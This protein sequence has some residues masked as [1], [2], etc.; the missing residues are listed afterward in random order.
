[1]K[2]GRW[3][4]L[5]EPL[6]RTGVRIRHGL[7]RRHLLRTRRLNHP[8]ISIGNLS[9][10][11][12]GK[13][14]LVLYFAEFLCEAGLAPAVLSRGYRGTSES[15]NR[16]VSDGSE[17]LAT[18]AEAGDEAC[19]LARNLR[20]VPV[21]MGKR[22]WVSGRLIERL[23]PHPDRVFL[24]DDGF[25]HLGLARDLDLVVC[26][27]TRPLLGDS[28]LP[29]G[30]LREPPRALARADAVLLTRCHLVESRLAR[31]D[32]EI[33]SLAPRAPCFQFRTE[34]VALREL[35]GGGAEE[36]SARAGRKGVVLAA[37]GNPDQFVKDVARAGVKIVN[38][39]LFR[40]HHPYT[41]EELDVV[42]ERAH[43]LGGEFVVTTDKDA[44]RLEGLDLRDLPFL[45]L[46]VRFRPADP[47]RLH[48]WLLD[49]LRQIRERSD[50]GP[51]RGGT[52]R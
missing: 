2:Y 4:E 49:R 36:P 19:M 5:A 41:Q 34:A 35:K 50:S 24:L 22:R 11:G 20:G 27:A 37:L 44:V 6:F 48:A 51:E 16:L 17:L 25:Q 21:A 30:R 23:H 12:T 47:D 13:S 14:P 45:A 8:V 33:R 29:S 43:R 15:K 39:F 46:R 32:E 1:M 31:L 40:D 18:P 52:T 38:E 3:A 42:I 28:L 26:D 7:Y 10:G 9:V